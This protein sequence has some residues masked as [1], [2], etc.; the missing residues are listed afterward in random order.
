MTRKAF[1]KKTDSFFAANFGQHYQAQDEVSLIQTNV[2][3]DFVCRRYELTD[4]ELEANVWG[5]RESSGNLNKWRRGHNAMSSSIAKKIDFS[6]PGAKFVYDLPVFNL[7]KYKRI[8][9]T[10]LLNLECVGSHEALV[11]LY[12]PDSDSTKQIK[13]VS[14]YDKHIKH[15]HPIEMFLKGN[16]LGFENL[17]FLLRMSKV[18]NDE[19]NFL[20][21]L[22]H[23]YAAFPCFAKCQLFNGYWYRLLLSVWYL[24]N[25]MPLTIGLIKP[26]IT[27][28]RQQVFC[29]I[30][31][32][33]LYRDMMSRSEVYPLSLKYKKAFQLSCFD[34]DHDPLQVPTVRRENGFM[35]SMR[36]LYST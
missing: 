25:L 8:S 4:K 33:N 13:T 28:I 30:C 10:D 14:Y 15:I 11:G 17:L 9:E 26:N 18:K 36:R 1:S 21:C 27:V 2:V 6:F 24:Q 3:L 7:L 31:P 20:K 12:E 16:V 5:E 22:A 29:D 19:E 32:T 23:L 34:Y 35:M